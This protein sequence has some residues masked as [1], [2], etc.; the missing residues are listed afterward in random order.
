M[1]ELKHPYFDYLF[2]S[3]IEYRD[4]GNYPNGKSL[5]FQNNKLIE[6]HGTLQALES[7]QELKRL[8]EQDKLNNV[9]RRRHKN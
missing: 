4:Y 9:K 5:N 6:I 2:K 1:S 7:E 8:Q 3:Y